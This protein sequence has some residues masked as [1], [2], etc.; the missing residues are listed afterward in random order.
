MNL[1]KAIF[2]KFQAT[3]TRLNTTGLLAVPNELAGKALV[4]DLANQ[5]IRTVLTSF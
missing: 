3:V 4:E 1:Q 5:T 2:T